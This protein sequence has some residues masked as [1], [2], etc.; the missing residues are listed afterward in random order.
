VTT[1]SKI[2]Q[3]AIIGNYGDQSVAEIYADIALTELA[4]GRERWCMAYFATQQGLPKNRPAREQFRNIHVATIKRME[5]DVREFDA[6]L[7]YR[8]R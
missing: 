8:G 7:L 4:I 3:E 1:F 5:R 6:E 2:S